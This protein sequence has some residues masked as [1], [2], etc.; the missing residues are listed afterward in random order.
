MKLT[1]SPKAYHKLMWLNQYSK[2]ETSGLGITS[3]EDPLYVLDI[4]V[5]KQTVS[6]VTTEFDD[7]GLAD[8]AAALCGKGYE[9]CQYMRIWVH[10]HPAGVN[11]PSAV[12][13]ETFSRALGK[14]DW[15]VML[16]LPKDGKFYCKMRIKAVGLKDSIE[17]VVPVEIDWL[18]APKEWVEEFA[19]N[20]DEEILITPKATTSHFPGTKQS[21]W[22]LIPE[23][24]WKVETYY[25]DEE[26]KDI[27]TDMYREGWIRDWEYEA[28][29]EALQK[30]GALPFGIEEQVD[31]YMGYGV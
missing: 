16:I 4:V 19:K 13:E 30:G 25:S 3:L 24:Q 10:T 11:S 15:A 31:F 20:V 6:S 14:A 1:L 29:L 28:S 2:N 5:P 7:E 9:M 21:D 17:V 18:N 27:L 12:D 26:M 23:D 8:L 22:D